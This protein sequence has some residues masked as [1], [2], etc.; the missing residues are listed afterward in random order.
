MTSNQFTVGLV[1]L[2][3]PVSENIPLAAATAFVQFEEELPAYAP[4]TNSRVFTAAEKIFREVRHLAPVEVK[5]R[6]SFLSQPTSGGSDFGRGQPD[7][8]WDGARVW[9]SSL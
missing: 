6:E 4:A 3:S 1:A 5:V 9:L 2:K 8:V 7:G